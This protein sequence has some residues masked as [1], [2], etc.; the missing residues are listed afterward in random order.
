LEVLAAS[1]QFLAKSPKTAEAFLRAFSKGVKFAKDNREK[2]VAE[3]EKRLGVN[4]KYAGMSYDE[5]INDT[6]ADG[7]LPSKVGMKVY[8]DL[9]AMSGQSKNG[10]LPDSR[11][12][13]RRY[14]DSYAKW[15]SK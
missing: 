3:L 7:R 13:D 12:L 5:V 1:Q 2:A 6:Y 10:P 14:M 4:A 8:W 9:E 15:S 11:W